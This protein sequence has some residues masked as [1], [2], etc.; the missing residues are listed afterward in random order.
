MDTTGTIFLPSAHSTISGEVDSLFNFILYIAIF[1]LLLITSATIYFVIRYRRRK[2]R[3]S[4]TPGMEYNVPLEITWTIIPLVLVFIIFFWGFK[5]YLKMNVVPA[6]ALEIKVTGQQWFWSFDYPQGA[7]SVN[8]LVVP[9]DKPIKLLMSSRD[10]IHSFFVPKF[11]IKMDVLPNRYTITWFEATNVG[12][13]ELFCAEYCGKSHSD[14][15]GTVKVVTQ[16]E[17]EEW[18]EAGSSLGEGMTLEEFGSQLYKSRAC[19]TCHSVDGTPNVGPSF[20]GVYGHTVE[21]EDGS[22]VTVD[23]NYIRESVLEPQ[24]KV[25][26]GYQPV[27][28]TFQGILKD[29]QIDAI[30][31][32]I[33]SLKD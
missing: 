24:A 7:N 28:P 17:Y 1:F 18:I 30:I 2:D 12:E 27:M 22:T 11:R 25:V 32:F 14:M 29:K 6:D 4:L 8:E 10:V 23:E 20:K 5:T 31:A 13:Y 16:R 21:M 26:K 9:V 3:A 33:K 19:I 15:I